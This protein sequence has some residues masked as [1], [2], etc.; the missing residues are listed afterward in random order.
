MQTPCN[1]DNNV[2]ADDQNQENR[3]VI[4][5]VTRET[6]ESLD[7]P[8]HQQVVIE[9]TQPPNHLAYVQPSN[10][11]TPTRPQPPRY[12]QAD[13]RITPPPGYPHHNRAVDNE[14]TLAAPGPPQPLNDPGDD[15][16]VSEKPPKRRRQQLLQLLK[17]KKW[18]TV[19]GVLFL[20]GIG[21]VVC[22]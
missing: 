18:Y 6:A 5:E 22:D 12:H 7:H 16:A 15:P 4:I 10:G 3:Q 11:G 9:A 8:M 1:D 17:D 14:R 2:R 19:G 13:I 20:G 21:F